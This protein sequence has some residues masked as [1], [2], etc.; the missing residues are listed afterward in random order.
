MVKSANVEYDPRA[1]LA[2]DKRERRHADKVR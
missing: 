1:D 2:R